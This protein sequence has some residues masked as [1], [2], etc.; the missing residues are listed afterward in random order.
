[1]GTRRFYVHVPLQ[2]FR[3]EGEHAEVAQGIHLI[4]RCELPELAGR[5]KELGK[6]EQR[7]I[8]EDVTHW[9]CFEQSDGDALSSAEKA[10]LFILALW[11]AKP[12]KTEMSFRFEI[13]FDAAQD[14]T[15]MYRLLDRMQFVQGAVEAKYTDDDIVVASVYFL[16][17]KAVT[18]PG[19]LNDAMILTLQGCWQGR[20]QAALVLSAA[21]AEALLTSS[22]KRGL[23]HRLSVA[24]ACL[25]H[26]IKVD[27]DAA[28]SEFKDCYAGRSD[29]VHGR[30][31][32]VAE[33]D[34]LKLVVRWGTVLRALW[35][36]I[37]VTPGLIATLEGTDMQRE[38]FLEAVTAGYVP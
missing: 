3:W 11:L 13:G 10:N 14:E 33:A 38:V 6:D 30:G 1:M 7:R 21:A 27:R 25:L 5:E 23:T 37:L 26:T 2:Q 32:N 9:L 4:R 34:R 15:I 12:T 8:N 20:W 31:M 19:R 29:V 16:A 22:K 17:L 28:Y 24:Y 35:R 36:H 18:K